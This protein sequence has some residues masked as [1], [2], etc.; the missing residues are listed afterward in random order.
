MKTIILFITTLSAGSVLISVSNGAELQTLES[1]ET[2]NL[3]E[4][5]ILPKKR[6]IDSFVLLPGPACVIDPDDQNNL[7][8]LCLKNNDKTWLK[9]I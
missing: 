2:K 8:E 6:D 4:K 5:E 3:G 7:V 1:L 9:A